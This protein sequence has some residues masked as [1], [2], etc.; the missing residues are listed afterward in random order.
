MNKKMI[1]TAT[2][3]LLCISLTGCIT[4]TP[5]QL[6]A[7]GVLQTVIYH[8]SNK[9]CDITID[10]LKYPFFQNTYQD[11][12]WAIYEQCSPHINKTVTLTYH[13]EGR[14]IKSAMVFDTL[15]AT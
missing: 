2:L 3:M 13:H 4:S 5:H 11:D 8:E 6:K 7:T 1:A 14:G 10:G 12:T 9:E 15:R